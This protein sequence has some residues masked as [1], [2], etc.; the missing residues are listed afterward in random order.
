MTPLPLTVSSTVVQWQHSDTTNY[1]LRFSYWSALK[2][3]TT[4]AESSL[5]THRATRRQ[6]KRIT[7][8]AEE[9]DSCGWQMK[10]RA[11]MPLCFDVALVG[12]MQNCKSECRQKVL[13]KFFL[14]PR[15]KLLW[16]AIKQNTHEL[17]DARDYKR[18]K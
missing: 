12:E 2:K 9:N 16:R 1:M 3:P 7:G 5:G 8:D 10:L 11:I 4:T 14:F 13:V 6:R 17:G 15:R 18:A